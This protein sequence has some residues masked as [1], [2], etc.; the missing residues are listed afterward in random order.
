MFFKPDGLKMYVLGN[1]SDNVNQYDLSVAWDIGTASYSQAFSIS[2]QEPAPAG[3][4]FKP[5]GL[6]MYVTG[7]N[8]DNV[9]EYD[10]SVAWDISTASYTQAFSVSAQ[11]TAPSG[12]LL[13]PDGLK[14]Y[15]IG[16]NSGNVNEYGLSTAW[17]ISTA[18]YS[19]AFSV[20]AQ[21][22]APTD[23]FFKPDGLKMY[24]IGNI[25]A[26]G[27]LGD[28]VNEYDLGTAWDIS[29]ASYLRNFSVAAQDTAPQSVFFK[30]DGTKMYVV[31][32]S[33]DSVHEYAITS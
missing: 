18:S 24:V 30:P 29:T 27:A 23:L 13:K 5:D 15:V 10:L 22:A 3:M 20:S 4:F 25:G 8:S 14:M 9:N 16:S 21:E 33:S 6:K 31:G 19:Q 2:A 1:V 28:Y 26:L 32:N 17:D 11:E 7:S 12:L